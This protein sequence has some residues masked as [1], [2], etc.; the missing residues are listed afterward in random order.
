MS[1]ERENGI[2]V[3]VVIDLDDPLKLGRVRVRFPHLEDQPSDW[4][5]LVSL[6]AGAS[7]GAFFSPEVNDEVLVAF[8]H[9]DPRRPYVL[10]ALWSSPDPP[11]KGDGKP[12]ENNWRQITSRSGHIFRLDDTKGKEKVEVTDKDGNRKIVIDSSGKKIEIDCGLGDV[13]I[14]ASA[15]VTVQGATVEIKADGTLSLEAGGTLTIKG[16]VVNIN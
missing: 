4:A 3:G 15:K 14:K 9:G 11:P 1:S 16:A 10:G 12:K 8:E 7:R 13:V 2:C 6:M 5:R